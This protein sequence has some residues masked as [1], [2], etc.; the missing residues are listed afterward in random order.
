M[1]P[2]TRCKPARRALTIVF[3]AALGF[4]ASACGRR[5]DPEAPP[6][7]SAVQKTSNNPADQLQSRNKDK[8]IVAPKSSFVLDPL[9]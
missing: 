4:A 7:P 8:A 2:T 3:V 5:G 9:L 6:D 1:I